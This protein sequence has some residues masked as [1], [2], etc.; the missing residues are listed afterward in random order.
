MRSLRWGLVLGGL[1]LAAFLPQAATGVGAATPLTATVGPG[2]NILMADANG[3]RVTHLDPGAYTI[4]VHDRS[5]VHNFHLHGPGV[6]K[7]TQIE[8]NEETVWNVTFTDG[9]Y[10]YQCDAHP[11]MMFGS[12]GAGNVPTPPP[13]PP[14]PPPTPPPPTTKTSKLTAT[15]G[16]GATISQKNK[17]SALIPPGPATITVN[18]KSAK[19][20]FHLTGPGVNK[21][22]GIAA[23]TTTTWKVT[24]K[25]GKKYTYRSDA[26]SSLKKTFTPV[27]P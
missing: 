9:L 25:A 4:T 13:P 23:K 7:F 22:T 27:R 20:N 15:V 3:N 8:L 2:F 12:F 14:P 19:D 11:S 16:P 6:E 5:D 1:G 24:L 10:E 18:D 26:H 17:V 21:K